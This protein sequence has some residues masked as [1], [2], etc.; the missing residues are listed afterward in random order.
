MLPGLCSFFVSWVR[1]GI[2][3][4]AS[5]TCRRISASAPLRVATRWRRLAV[6]SSSPRMA[7]SVTAAHLCAD[8]RQ[9]GYFINAFDLYRRGVHIHNKQAGGAQMGRFAEGHYVQAVL[10][11]Q[12]RGARRQRSRQ[13]HHPIVVDLPGGNHH[14]RRAQRA[15]IPRQTLFIKIFAY[16]RYGPLGNPAA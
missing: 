2:S 12:P 1:P 4:S 8:A 9:F 13:T 11:G 7:R 10:M 15:L 5:G 16:N 14:H 3:D 6:K